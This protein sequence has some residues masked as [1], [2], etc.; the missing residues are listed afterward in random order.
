MHPIGTDFIFYM[1]IILLL[2]LLS[3]RVSSAFYASSH[4]LRIWSSYIFFSLFLSLYL[5]HVLKTITWMFHIYMLQVR[6]TQQV[7]LFCYWNN[8]STPNSLLIT[9][10]D[11]MKRYFKVQIMFKYL[12]LMFCMIRWAREQLE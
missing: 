12:W 6:R 11:M 9:L 10:Y 8:I 3:S 5:A 2:S 1:I 4:F 7:A